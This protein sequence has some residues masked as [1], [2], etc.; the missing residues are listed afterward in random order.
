MT[1]RNYDVIVQFPNN[2]FELEGK[3][4]TGNVVI[5][6][7]SGA[8]GVIAN[9]DYTAN[10]LKVKYSNIF[11]KFKT[12]E[13]LTSKV[14]VPLTQ[15]SSITYSNS[16]TSTAT[17][18]SADLAAFNAQLPDVRIAT[19]LAPSTNTLLLPI[20]ANSNSEI[21]VIL[22]N[23]QLAPDQYIWS[24]DLTPNVQG[25]I[26]QYVTIGGSNT[27]SNIAALGANAVF[28]KNTVQLNANSTATLRIDS[29]NL[30]STIF[31]AS[32]TNS[33]AAIIT[34]NSNAITSITNSPFIAEKNAFTQNPIV[35]MIS[36]YYPGKYYPLNK[37][38]NPSGDGER[39][40]WPND[41]PFRLAEINGDI[42]SDI[43]Y[44]VTYDGASYSPYPIN[45][46]AIEQASDGKI[47]DLTI[48][49]FNFEG[50][51]SSLVENSFIAG[52]NTANA[53]MAMVNN[54]LVHGIDPRTIN[55]TPAQVGGSTGNTAFDT[56]TRARANGL[57]YDSS[58][59]GS[60]GQANA[61][62]TRS[63]S[64]SNTVNGAWQE[65]TID[66]RDL[67]GGVVEIKTTFANFLDYW[68]EYSTVKT[69]YNNVYEMVSTMPYRVGDNV[70]S[71]KGTTQATITAIEENRFL[72][73][74]NNLPATTAIS[75]P[76]YIVNVEADP[77]AFIED[78]FKIDSLESLNDT[79]A[80]FSLVSWL[81]YFKYV[82]PS[83]KYYKNTC[84][85]E[86]KGAECQYPGPGDGTVGLPIP[87][88]T[89]KG[90]P[91]SVKA[92]GSETT[93][94]SDD[95]CG[96]SLASCQQRNNDIHFGGFP[97]TGRTI[98]RM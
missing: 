15:N 55:F 62:F 48:N 79:V 75:D 83:R 18:N 87:G 26:S 66:S 77:E 59:V 91:K 28:L 86:Y 1:G 35:R 44:N 58:I 56:L 46:S 51:I 57:N 37:Y 96:K 80:T 92:D 43:S 30:Q 50:A 74:S 64:L 24:N 4:E 19:R 20:S 97:A 6:S 40:G 17:V 90:N 41:F 2:S 34:A 72:F 78:V 73:L 60:Y 29:G 16:N 61:S 32:N 22:D 85:W 23:T 7:T 94:P 65:E 52:N 70:K 31:T 36:I 98:P 12:S 67:L 39:R 47:N 81:Q 71:S 53:C 45:I 14:L 63:Q 13:N 21:T 42:I 33:A 88:T 5:G 76:L 9:I 89:K 38:G 25:T 49:I 93:N 84:G 82:I 54:Q 68:P 69:I 11:E 10:T 8:T 3:F 95:V 27:F